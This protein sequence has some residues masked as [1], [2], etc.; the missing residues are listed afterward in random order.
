MMFWSAGWEIHP[1]FIPLFL[2]QNMPQGIKKLELN[3]VVSVNMLGRD[4]RALPQND[5]I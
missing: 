5:Y 1:H 4:T 2:W 3:P